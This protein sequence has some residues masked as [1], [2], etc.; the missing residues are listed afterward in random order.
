ML[1]RPI[2]VDS[3][4]SQS[5]LE[6]Q[7]P[8]P[9]PDQPDLLLAQPLLPSQGTPQLFNYSTKHTSTRP[10]GHVSESSKVSQRCL[11]VRPPRS[12]SPLSL[13][14]PS[15]KMA[16]SP[17]PCLLYRN[18]VGS[19]GS[20]GHEVVLYRKTWPDLGERPITK[21]APQTKTTDVTSAIT[22][23]GCLLFQLPTVSSLGFT[24][25]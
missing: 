19:T 9:R 25:I 24:I 20:N 13:S 11:V 6:T 8:W 14:F 15:V 16:Q 4:V 10:K 12:H 23:V 5:Q 17:L 22:V 2:P 7:P 3:W 18:G 1:T 21:V